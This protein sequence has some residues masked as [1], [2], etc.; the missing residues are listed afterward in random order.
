MRKL[1][2]CFSLLQLRVAV[3]ESLVYGTDFPWSAVE[4]T[5]AFVKNREDGSQY[6][7]WK[8]KKHKIL[9]ISVFLNSNIVNL[10]MHLKIK[11]K[12]EG[13]LGNKAWSSFFLEKQFAEILKIETSK[14]QITGNAYCRGA[15]SYKICFA[16]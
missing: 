8:N 13:Q 12:E 5:P 3:A 7:F 6:V 11:T 2:I 1:Q 16:V 15:E 10:K 4:S 9:F 14:S